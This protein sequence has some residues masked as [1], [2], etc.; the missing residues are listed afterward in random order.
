M[1]NK[2]VVYVGLFAKGQCQEQPDAILA[3]DFEHAHELT[4]RVK[5]V[6]ESYDRMVGFEGTAEGRIEY[7]LEAVKEEV[8]FDVITNELVRMDL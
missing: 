5:V 1:E 4:V 2:D 8:H 7:I 6:N 3:V